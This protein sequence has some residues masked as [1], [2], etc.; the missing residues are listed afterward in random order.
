MKKKCPSCGSDNI[1]KIIYGLCEPP[2]KG[3]ILGGCCVITDKNG[4]IVSPKWHCN[5]CETEF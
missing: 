5:D 1:S 2:K 3:E 4:R